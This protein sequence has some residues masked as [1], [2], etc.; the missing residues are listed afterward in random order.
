MRR[1]VL[2]S[3]PVSR[4]VQRTAYHLNAIFSCN[5]FSSGFFEYD[6]G[7]WLRNFYSYAQHALCIFVHA[8]MHSVL[9]NIARIE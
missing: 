9:V 2:S 6:Y 1:N 8:M 5:Y 3:K 4:Q 7:L